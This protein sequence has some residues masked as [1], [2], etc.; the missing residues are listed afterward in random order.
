MVERA[1]IEMAAEKKNQNR[2]WI[3]LI[4]KA[5]RIGDGD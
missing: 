4:G 2:V 5:Y 1:L 3:N